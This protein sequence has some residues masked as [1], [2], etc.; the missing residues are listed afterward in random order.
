[1]KKNRLSHCS[2]KKKTSTSTTICPK[3]FAK[4]AH[5]RDRQPWRGY[6]ATR[7]KASDPGLT[8]NHFLSMGVDYAPQGLFWL[9]HPN[10]SGKL[11]WTFERDF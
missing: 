7:C 3:N 1:M 10:D 6:L 4:E 2:R 9:S 5:D 11:F 8:L